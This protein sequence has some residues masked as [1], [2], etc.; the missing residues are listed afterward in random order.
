MCTSAQ[1]GATGRTTPP[2]VPGLAAP[3]T[4]DRDR[5][6][7]AKQDLARRSWPS[8]N[9]YA[10]AKSPVIID[11]TRRAEQWAQDTSWTIGQS[12]P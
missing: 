7:R 5:Y 2:A 3:G 1:P 11:L 12:P 4:F 9:D 8:M 6:Q 10:D